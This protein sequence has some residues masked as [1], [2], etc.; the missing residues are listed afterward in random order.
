MST[1]FPTLP[2]QTNGDGD[3][4]HY[5]IYP[6]YPDV[7][8][9]NILDY[10]LDL[11]STWTDDYIWNL[12]P[13]TL[14]PESNPPRL[15]GTMDMGEDS[16]VSPD[17]WVVVGVLWHISKLFPNVVI[18]CANSG[19]GANCSIQDGEGEFLL[20][21]SALHIPDWLKPETAENRIWIHNGELKIIPLEQFTSHDPPPLALD[22]ALSH[23]RSAIRSEGTT[24]SLFTDPGMNVAIQDKIRGFPQE[25]QEQRHLARVMIPRLLAQVIHQN[26]QLIAPGV[27][28]FYTR[29]TQFKKLREFKYF[30]PND[31]VTVNIQFSRPLFAMIKSQKFTPP[32]AFPARDLS[33]SEREMYSLGIKLTCAFELLASSDSP[34]S[35]RIIDLWN[36]EKD[37]VV[38][39]AEIKEWAEN[40]EEPSDEEWM[41]LSAEDVKRIIAE[42]KSEEEQVREMIANFE[43][44]MEG[45]SGFEGIDDEFAE[46]DSDDDMDDDDDEELD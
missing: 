42:D 35:Q 4:L 32:P 46:F 6:V 21:E 11:M 28:S 1:S 27:Q 20:I 38:E 33:A 3:S 29:T 41:T 16:G 15:H 22:D 43:R 5:A 26:P 9:K 17:E 45:E 23:F 24:A 14:N 36:T 34:W 19:N 37:R 8:L 44:F 39:D 30:A 25:L 18:R 2:I 7:N 31:W 10:T 40:C 12:D 13:F